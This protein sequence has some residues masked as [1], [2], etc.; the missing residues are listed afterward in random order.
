MVLI[1][2][3]MFMHDQVFR[4]TIFVCSRERVRNII[5][6]NSPLSLRRIIFM[7]KTGKQRFLDKLLSSTSCYLAL[8]AQ[9]NCFTYT[10]HMVPLP[11][12]KTSSP[13]HVEET[14]QDTHQSWVCGDFA[15]I[16]IHLYFPRQAIHTGKFRTW[17]VS[18]P[19]KNSSCFLTYTQAN[20]I[21]GWKKPCYFVSSYTQVNKTNVK[22]LLVWT[23]SLLVSYR[24]LIGF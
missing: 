1:F 23:W 22:N 13:G 24:I 20:N 21:T 10:T 11:K 12:K 17:Q 6:E 8:H 5:F 4:S 18:W 9:L 19:R 2:E 3:V 15:I 16:F 14:K 7:C